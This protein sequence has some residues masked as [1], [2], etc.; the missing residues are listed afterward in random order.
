MTAPAHTLTPLD[1][2]FLYM[3]SD[4][5]P[6]HIGSIGIF[7]GGPLHDARGFL[8]LEEVRNEVQS[9]L[10]L[11][12]KLRQCVRSRASEPPVSSVGV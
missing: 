10:H 12:P 9:R 2:S 4:H 8:R 6:M 7:E 1:A 3:E 11:V 5:T